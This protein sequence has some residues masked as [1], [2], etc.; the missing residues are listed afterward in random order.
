M[1]YQTFAMA[2]S[3]STE[4]DTGT[5]TSS[6]RGWGSTDRDIP[7]WASLLTLALAKNTSPS[8]RKPEPKWRP[9]TPP[10]LNPVSCSVVTVEFRVTACWPSPM[11]VAVSVSVSS[12]NM[13][14]TFAPRY[15]SLPASCAAAAPPSTRHA[16]ATAAEIPHDPNGM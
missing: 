8:M 14:G 3:W 9:N 7:V 13:R 16:A 11:V 1:S 12:M 2:P 10:I 6:A 4:P 15:Q 5:S